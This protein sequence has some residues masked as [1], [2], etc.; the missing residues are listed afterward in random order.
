MNASLQDHLRPD[1]ADERVQN[2]EPAYVKFV[3]DAD[4][5]VALF[6]AADEL[7]FRK[8]GAEISVPEIAVSNATE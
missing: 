3:P 5:R 2:M 7:R 4:G 1:Q 6:Q 8:L